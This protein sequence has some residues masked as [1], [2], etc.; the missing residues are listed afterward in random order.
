M[1]LMFFG[2]EVF[3][4]NIT[5]WKVAVGTPCLDFV[6][7]KKTQLLCSNL[8]TWMI[9]PTIPGGGCGGLKKKCV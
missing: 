6:E 5:T 1:G 2:A 8:P 9:D 4:Q 3:N 7:R